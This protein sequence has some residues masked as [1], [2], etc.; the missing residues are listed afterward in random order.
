MNSVIIGLAKGQH[1]DIT[2]QMKDADEIL[3]VFEKYNLTFGKKYTTIVRNGPSTITFKSIHAENIRSDIT[4]AVCELHEMA[5]NGT[6]GNV[7]FRIA[8]HNPQKKPEQA[9]ENESL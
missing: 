5:V 6:I 3:K 4:N 2:A 9:D 7:Y 8:S 1:A